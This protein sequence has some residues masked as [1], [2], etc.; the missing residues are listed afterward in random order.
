MV[1][2]KT[3]VDHSRADESKFH[4][5]LY[6]HHEITDA[7]PRAKESVVSKSCRP[8]LANQTICFVTRYS[9]TC[10]PCVKVEIPEDQYILDSI[11]YSSSINSAMSASLASAAILG[12]SAS[13]LSLSAPS[14]KLEAM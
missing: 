5:S 12:L 4:E 11:E 1:A 2:R 9:A 3:D 14:F 13:A 8:C 6:S 7:R 10:A